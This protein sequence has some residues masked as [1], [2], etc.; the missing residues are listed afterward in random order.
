MLD[1]KKI[2]EKLEE[3]RGVLLLQLQDIGKMNPET[4]EWEAVPEEMT[5]NESDQ[6]SMADRFED[7][8]ERSSTIKVL[9]DRLVNIMLALKSLSK[10]SF[11][12]CKVCK[13]QIEQARIE[14]NSAAT[15]CKK[16]LEN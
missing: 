15:T 4:E 2:K 10:E 9:G 12:I 13:K 5:S 1:K 11:G 7:F 3:E 8:E 16:H 6:N 14:A